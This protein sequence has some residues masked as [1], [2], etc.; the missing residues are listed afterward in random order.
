MNSSF[1][2]SY[3][4]RTFC[5]LFELNV[6]S[7]HKVLHI[8]EVF[9]KQVINHVAVE[10]PITEVLEDE[11]QV[12]SV[13]K[14]FKN[15][16]YMLGFLTDNSNKI[17]NLSMDKYNKLHLLDTHEDKPMDYCVSR[18]KEFV[19]VSLS[20]NSIGVFL[21][22]K[23]RLYVDDFKSISET[24]MSEFEERKTNEMLFIDINNMKK[25]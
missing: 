20:E 19:Y 3:S 15:S 1:F 24:P 6:R 2:G 22:K 13:F 17:N 11:G 14:K 8:Y 18:N 21:G 12:P 7:V 9:D 4:K 23:Q 5:D 16:S 25:D 10:L